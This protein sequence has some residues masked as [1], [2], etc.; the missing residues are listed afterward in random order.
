MVVQLMGFPN[1]PRRLIVHSEEV[2]ISPGWSIRSWVGTTSYSFVWGVAGENQ[3][4]SD[5]DTVPVETLE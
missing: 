2:V 3:I 5:M 1:E 4:F